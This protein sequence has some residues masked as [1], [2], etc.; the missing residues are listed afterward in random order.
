MRL[1]VVRHGIAIDRADPAC[2]PDPDRYLTD[3]GVEK[4]AAAAQ[5]LA[6]LIDDG[7]EIWTS[8]FVRARQT[9]ELLAGA[10]GSDP[11]DVVETD[12]LRPERD[13]AELF[14]AVEDAKHD[15]VLC[16]GHAPNLDWVVG[17][18][19]TGRIVDCLHLKKAG[20]AC[21]ELPR[22]RREGGALVWM[23]PPKVLRRLGA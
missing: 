18:A 4:T 20:A 21:L 3:E 15:A 23:L 6:S 13:P 11:G 19:L 17:Y 14:R 5:G 12:A 9:A 1:Y 22:R 8:P 10:L 7:P 16:V 2:P